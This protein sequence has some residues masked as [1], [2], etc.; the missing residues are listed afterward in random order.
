MT[1]CHKPGRLRA[2]VPAPDRNPS[3]RV[4]LWRIAAYC[5]PF[6]LVALLA[7]CG[8][9]PM[10]TPEPVS[11]TGAPASPTA[12]PIPAPEPTAT[13]LPTPEPTPSVIGNCRN[14][15]K[16]QPGEGCHYTGGG[17]SRADVILSAQ[18]D[19]TICREGGPAKQ[20][21]LT[22][23]NL[24][25]CTNGFERDDAFES[26]I[27]VRENPGGSWT[28]N[29]G[30][31]TPTV[32]P[33]PTP[34]PEPT[35]TP[36]PEPTATPTSM[37]TATPTPTPTPEPTVTPRPTPTP[38]P[39]ATPR[40][41]PTPRPT[42]TP[43]STSAPT[44]PPQSGGPCTVGMTLSQGD[45]CTVSIPGLHVGTDRF[46]NRG[47]NGCYGGICSGRSVNLSGFRASKSGS[48]WTIDSLP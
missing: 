14:G 47:G 4:R 9:E 19:G 29:D 46:E 43:R 40:P 32:A 36:T 17:I 12:T 20:F 34:T 38:R 18:H 33:T 35:P 24:R 26:D 15:I 22:V 27:T 16:L 41:T 23:D 30:T 3:S 7:A 5:G 10:A 37:P 25:L 39:T 45:Y 6:L 2:A 31:A 8:A 28:V 1:A 42:S 13:P 21:G 44:S 11:A 48:N